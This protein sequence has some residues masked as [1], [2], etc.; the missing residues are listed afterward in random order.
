MLDFSAP[1]KDQLPKIHKIWNSTTKWKL[2]NQIKELISLL[3][4]LRVLKR[5]CKIKNFLRISSSLRR[6]VWIKITKMNQREQSKQRRISRLRY[7]KTSM[8]ELFQYSLSIWMSS[9]EM[10]LNTTKNLDRIYLQILSW[11]F[12]IRFAI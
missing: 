11:F 6:W 4:N 2:T 10:L 3:K 9:K 7:L 8:A 5:I 1:M 12:W